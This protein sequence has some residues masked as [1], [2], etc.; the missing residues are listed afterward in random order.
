MRRVRFPRSPRGAIA[1]TFHFTVTLAANNASGLAFLT[2]SREGSPHLMAAENR[3]STAV[4][5]GPATLNDGNRIC[6]CT[7]ARARVCVMSEWVGVE[8]E[9][10]EKVEVE[11]KQRK[12]TDEGNRQR[13]E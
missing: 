5:G 10:A 11:T 8:E 2:A 4:R 6:T 3:C 12:A 9:V 1:S 13:A 7:C